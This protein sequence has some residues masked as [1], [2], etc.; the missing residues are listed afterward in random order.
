MKYIFFYL[1]FMLFTFSCKKDKI[2]N[3]TYC[4]NGIYCP[5]QYQLRSEPY[6]DTFHKSNKEL[7][8]IVSP[9]YE[10]LEEY[11]YNEPV[12]NPNNSFEF[13]FI[14]EKPY[15][16]QPTREL[17]IYNF[18]SNTTEVITDKVFYGV[19]WSKKNW[20]IFTGNDYQVYKIKANGDSLIQLTN[21]GDY[22]NYP[23]WSPSGEKFVYF[24]A[25]SSGSFPMK[26]ANT[27]GNHIDSI[28]FPMSSWEWLN[29]NEIIYSNVGNTE[30]RRYDLQNSMIE[31]IVNQ[32]SIGPSGDH[33]TVNQD[34]EIYTQIDEGL[35]RVG[36]SGNID[37]LD[38][39]YRTYSSGYAEQL[40]DSKILLQRFITDTTYYED[41][42]VYS[43]TYI[44][45]LDEE[46]GEERRIKIPE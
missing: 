15:E 24:D 33:I 29:E 40:T 26:I 25:S 22:S 42:I 35:I 13:V 6:P 43:G 8:C 14:R 38:T 46:T 32:I 11:T 18:C 3:N 19:D 5:E 39:N 21:T 44:S 9:Q 30:L 36:L 10:Y 1:V 45:I 27:Y 37:F 41:C 17:C 31:T 4:S 20:L 12:L 7:Q 28:D 16:I 23:K 2:D 34:Q